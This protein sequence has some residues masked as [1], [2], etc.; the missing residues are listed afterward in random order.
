MQADECSHVGGKLPQR[1]PVAA[2]SQ[3]ARDHRPHPRDRG[4]L[5]AHSGHDLVA[6]LPYRRPQLLGDGFGAGYAQ[7][8]AV[9]CVERPRTELG[10]LHAGC[11]RQ[12]EATALQLCDDLAGLPGGYLAYLRTPPLRGRRPSRSSRGS[13][14]FLCLFL[15][16]PYHPYHPYHRYHRFPYLL[17][18]A[19]LY[20]P[21]VAYLRDGV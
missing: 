19:L 14:G 6:V 1:H 18:L 21:L 7:P 20:L 5:D 12:L 13:R 4:V 11:H 8:V 10:F 16:A 2:F 3:V 15:P 17:L 9:G